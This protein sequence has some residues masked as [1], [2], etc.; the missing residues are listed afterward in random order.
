MHKQQVNLITFLSS[1]YTNINSKLFGD[2]YNHLFDNIWHL[3]EHN[4]DEYISSIINN[5]IKQND[6]NMRGYGYWIWKP[7]IIYKK[8]QEL[9]D[10]DIL[11]FL[12]AH[13]DLDNYIEDNKFKIHLL[14]LINKEENHILCGSYCG[15]NDYE[16]T[17][18]KCINVI[19]NILNHKFSL[20]ELKQEQH[21]CGILIIKKDEI[22]LE[23]IKTWLDI[24]IF[25]QDIITDK[26]NDDENNPTEFKEHR[27]DQSIFSLICK[28]YKIN[29]YYE[30]G[31]GFFHGNKYILE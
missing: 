20:D 3:T 27:H 13:C 18:N 11:I 31:W 14:D 19:E 8:L 15:S 21:E 28:Y 24:M 12:D 22:S 1:N 23:M 7:Y 2:K 30:L 25:N 4:L 26:Y 16:F 9:N 10:N 5:I 29:I 17:S 6:G